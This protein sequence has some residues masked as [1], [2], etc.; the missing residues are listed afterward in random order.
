MSSGSTNASDSSTSSSS[1]LTSLVSKPL[2]AGVYSTVLDRIFLKNE[3][4]KCFFVGNPES[5]YFQS[6]LFNRVLLFLQTGTN[7]ARLKQ[8]GKNGILIV[9]NIKS[10]DDIYEFLLRMITSVKNTK[11][12]II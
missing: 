3:N 5:P 10:M 2:L 4:M 12:D 8:V 9:E 11:T 7:K 1:L 6:E